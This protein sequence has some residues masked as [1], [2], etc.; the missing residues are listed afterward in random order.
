MR[1]GDDAA[2]GA[3]ADRAGEVEGGGRARPAGED[4]APQRGQLGL[5]RVDP[6]LERV[7]VLVAR[8]GQPALRA[9]GRV[10]RGEVRAEVEEA[11]WSSA[12]RARTSSCPLAAAATPSAALSSST[13]P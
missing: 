5:E 7:D 13:A 3:P 2:L 9:P 6:A 11:A 8:A 10:G 12:A 1:Q 4:E